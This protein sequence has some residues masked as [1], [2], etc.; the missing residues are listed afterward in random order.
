VPD[1]AALVGDFTQAVVFTHGSLGLAATDS[2]GDYFTKGLTVLAMN[3]P[4]AFRVEYT[5]AFQ[6]VT[7]L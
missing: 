5:D 4:L 2:Y 7:G 6:V 3:M 1:G